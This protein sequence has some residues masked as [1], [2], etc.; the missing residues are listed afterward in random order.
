[1]ISFWRLFFFTLSVNYLKFEKLKQLMSKKNI[2]LNLN[3]IIY[4]EKYF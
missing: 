4:M 3:I 1:M 2:S